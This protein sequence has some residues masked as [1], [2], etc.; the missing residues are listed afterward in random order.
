MAQTQNAAAPFSH[1][2][3][4]LHIGPTG[5]Y[6]VD[7]NGSPFLVHGDTA[8]SL[9]SGLRAEEAGRYLE[10][11]ARKGFN[12]IIV[13]LIEHKFKGPPNRYGDYPFA[14]MG[15]EPTAGGARQG[16][17]HADYPGA[18]FS[19]PSEAYFAHADWVIEK[20][21]ELGIVVFL[22]PIYLG[23]RNPVH[24]A[25]EGWYYEALGN[26][27]AR[28]YAYGRYLG[29]RYGR[30]SNIVWMMSGDRNPEG[31]REHVN[32][33]AWGIKEG[34]PEH[35]M[36][37]HCAPENAAAIQFAPDGWL[38]L[39]TVYTYE[40]V[41]RKLLAEYRRQPPLPFVLIESTYEGEHNAS[42][43]QIRRQAYWAL[44]CGATGQFLGNRP[45][46]LYDPGWAEAMDGQGSRDMVHLRNLFISRPWHDLVPDV[47]H[48]VVTAGLG[49]FRGLDYLAAARTSDGSTM[50][51]YM[52]TARAVTVDLARLA[53][54]LVRGWWYSPR[55]GT[56]ELAGDYAG[57]G[58]LE[59][60][61]PGEGDW[62]LVIDDAARGLP[63]PGTPSG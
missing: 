58:S 53:E 32:A 50:I 13:N 30:Y 34:A 51:A 49:E 8:W 2:S 52:P 23:Y 29:R 63:A 45:I 54:A 3:L 24:D 40:I 4:P 44:L 19:A 27:A 46:W 14:G 38:T 60:A 39:N 25:D 28:C 47:E 1:A 16:V 41:H 57:G 55:T 36:T 56:A 18:D 48:A 22:A 37:A 7:Q 62:V 9:I 10:N 61:P 42:P 5:R 17:A 6:L 20:A 31:A 35:L 15:A 43:V 21:A 12:A 33:V 26:G 11:R 59:L